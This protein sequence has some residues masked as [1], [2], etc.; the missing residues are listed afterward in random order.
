MGPSGAFVHSMPVLRRV[1]R[2]WNLHRRLE[3]PWPNVRLGAR[4]VVSGVLIGDECALEHARR[5]AADRRPIGGRCETGK[6]SSWRGTVP[7]DSRSTRSGLSRSWPLSLARVT[8]RS[9]RCRRPASRRMDRTR[10]A[11]FYL[12]HGGGLR[13]WRSSGLS[14][15]SYPQPARTPRCDI[16][17][18]CGAFSLQS[19]SAWLGSR[20]ISQRP[21]C[22]GW[23]S[24]PR[25]FPLCS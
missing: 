7:D 3:L 21:G 17:R 23:S 19:L 20:P 2:C 18:W 25:Q 16:P 8:E 24:Q 22:I 6:S 5:V 12:P 10:N 14:R 15:T 13:D 9:N 11:K 4:V 1:A